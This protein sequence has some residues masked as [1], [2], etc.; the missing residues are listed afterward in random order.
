MNNEQIFYLYILL[1]SMCTQGIEY[2]VLCETNFYPNNL[3]LPYGTL[4][5][6]INPNRTG[7]LIFS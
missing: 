6:I 1:Y 4:G 3:Y 5:E 2:I 7:D